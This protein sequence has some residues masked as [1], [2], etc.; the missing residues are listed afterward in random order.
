MYG[1]YFGWYRRQDEIKTKW[2]L[3]EISDYE[4]MVDKYR[5]F[6][7]TLNVFEPK[8]FDIDYNKLTEKKR[9][10]KQETHYRIYFWSRY[11]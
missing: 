4:L 9:S 11:R 7:W 6:Y 2:C 5:T 10:C 8:I 3:A 1:E